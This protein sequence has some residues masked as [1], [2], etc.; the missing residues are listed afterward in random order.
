MKRLL[1][2]VF[3]CL[4][5]TGSVAI[6]RE[7]SA[8]ASKKSGPVPA[9]EVDCSRVND[10]G[11]TSS[12][13]ERFSKSPALKDAGIGVETKEGVVT[14]TGKVKTGGLKGAATRVTRSVD[15]VKKVDNQLS[16]EPKADGKGSKSNN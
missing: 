11:I 4:F 1:L 6:A 2:A 14:L 9:E 5:V 13:K 15:C 3:L 10:A 16:V 7:G 12:V 8:R